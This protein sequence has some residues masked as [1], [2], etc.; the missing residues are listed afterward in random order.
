MQTVTYKS[1]ELVVGSAKVEENVSA[2][3]GRFIVVARGADGWDYQFHTNGWLS[4]AAELAE[5]INQGGN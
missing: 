4:T 5:E 1:I 2:L 3:P